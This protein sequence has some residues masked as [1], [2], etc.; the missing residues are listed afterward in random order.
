MNP[1]LRRPAFAQFMS[2]RFRV[3]RRLG[4]DTDIVDVLG[5]IPRMIIMMIALNDIATLKIG[6]DTGTGTTLLDIGTVDMITHRR[7]AGGLMTM[8]VQKAGPAGVTETGTALREKEMKTTPQ[9]IR[10]DAVLSVVP[11]GVQ[12]QKNM[13]WAID[14]TLRCLR[15]R[16][17]QAEPRTLHQ[18]TQLLTLFLRHLLPLSD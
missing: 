14:H 3:L 8:K 9:K 1:F 16:E 15:E 11:V 12:S 10:A 4:Q 13:I 2:M 5:P 6:T 17:I 7:G 18:A